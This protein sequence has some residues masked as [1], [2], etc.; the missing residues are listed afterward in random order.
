MTEPEDRANPP[1]V[2]TPRG[3]G[4]RAF[5]KTTVADGIGPSLKRKPGGQPGNRNAGKPVHPL[6]ALQARVRELRKRARALIRRAE[7]K[8]R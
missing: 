5:A 8:T 6:S 3:E 1:P 2:P 4:V 7:G